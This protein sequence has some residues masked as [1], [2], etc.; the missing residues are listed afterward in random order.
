MTESSPEFGRMPR[1]DDNQ[2]VDY[3]RV[4]ADEILGEE[5]SSQVSD[6]RILTNREKF[7]KTWSDLKHGKVEES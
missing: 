7:E 3:I 5:I 2:Y 4:L 6:E 1:P